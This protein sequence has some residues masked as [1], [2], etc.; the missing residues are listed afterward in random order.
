MP[1]RQPPTAVRFGYIGQISPQKGV[2]T[3]VDAF[4]L[5]NFGETAQLHIYGNDKQN[6]E[7]TQRLTDLLTGSTGGVTLHGPF[8]P[9][10]LGEVLAG[11]DILV[12]PSTWWENNPRVIQEAFA[13]KAPVIA[14]DVAGIAEFVRHEVSGL[15]FERGDVSDLARQMRRIVE[16]PALMEQLRA[17]IPPVKTIEQE[18]G[19]LIDIYEQ[20]KGQVQ[21]E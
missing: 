9:D 17:G 21:H 19:E 1:E 13:A 15:L 20:V 10:R 3:L 4:L 12:A 18:V 6:P 7:Y 5:N 2:H 11:I 14:S 16:E 8:S